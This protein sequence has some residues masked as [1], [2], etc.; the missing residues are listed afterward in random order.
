M[1]A[2]E[3]WNHDA[4]FD[5]VDRWISEPECW[6]YG[7]TQRADYYGYGGAFIEDMWDAYR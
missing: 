5:Y 1:N 4:F 7:G 6:Y 3:I 2:I